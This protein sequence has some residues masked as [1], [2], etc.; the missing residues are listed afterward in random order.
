MLLTITMILE[1]SQSMVRIIHTTLG[2]TEHGMM[3]VWPILYE[4]KRERASSTQRKVELLPSQTGV[5]LWPVLQRS[6][7]YQYLQVPVI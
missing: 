7:E 5:T 4:D 6:S 2:F 1:G 3:K